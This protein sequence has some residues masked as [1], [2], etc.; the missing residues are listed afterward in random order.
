M[1]VS[2][3]E[4]RVCELENSVT[5]MKAQLDNMH[6]MAFL[7]QLCFCTEGS[8]RN[9]VG[10]SGTLK[11]ILSREANGTLKGAELKKLQ[12]LKSKYDLATLQDVIED[13]K[14]A[15]LPQAHPIVDRNNNA[16]SEQQLKDAFVSRFVNT[17]EMDEAD[18]DLLFRVR[19]DLKNPTEDM[20]TL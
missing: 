18:V 3:L 16:V 14:A 10:V 4:S 1:R 12:T 6:K 11:R 20:V 19:K 5:T 15:R 7:G 9:F 2:E 17:G 8:I 13:V